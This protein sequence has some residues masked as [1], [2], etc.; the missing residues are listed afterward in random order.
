MPLRWIAIIIFA[1]ALL[2]WPGG[3]YGQTGKSIP[4]TLP[5]KI[6]EQPVE[7]SPAGYDTETCRS[8][9]GRGKDH[10]AVGLLCDAV[11]A[12]WENR[13]L[14]RD[15]QFNTLTVDF[16][17]VALP[18]E[19]KGSVPARALARLLSAPNLVPRY[20]HGGLVLRNLKLDG[21]LTLDHATVD[22]P[23]TFINATFVGVKI[24]RD[25][26]GLPETKYAISLSAARFN[27]RVLI[28]HS[29]I[30][31]PVKIKDSHF[32]RG[33]YFVDVNVFGIES[34]L[35]I[36]DSTIDLALTFYKMRMPATKQSVNIFRST[37]AS[38]VVFNSEL[39]VD[40]QGNA[41]QNVTLIK[42]SFKYIVF[43]RNQ[44]EGQFI[45]N[46]KLEKPLQKQDGSSTPPVV[47]ANRIGGGFTFIAPEIHPRVKRLDLSFNRAEGYSTVYVSQIWNGQVDLTN[48]VFSS[49]LRLAR[50]DP[51]SKSKFTYKT[52]S[53]M[54]LEKLQA[55]KDV[56]IPI[57]DKKSNRRLVVNLTAAEIDT[58]AWNFSLS[59]SN[60]WEGAGLKYK[61]WGD[62]DLKAW[63]QTPKEGE[64]LSDI[65]K[66]EEDFL[67]R[68]LLWR[69][70]MAKPDVDAL[71]YMADY[72]ESR[73]RRIESRD[74]REEAKERNYS[75]PKDPGFVGC[76]F[77]WEC[78]KSQVVLW[79][80]SPGGYG[81]KPERALGLLFI[82]WFVFAIFYKLYSKWDELK[83]GW[84]GVKSELDEVKS[85]WD[86]V[87]IVL[88]KVKSKLFAWKRK[89][90]SW[91]KRKESTPATDVGEPPP[92]FLQ[93][94]QTVPLGPRQ[95]SVWRYSLDA[96]LP[97]INLHAYD[98]Y[99]LRNPKL[100]WIPAFQHV[101][102][103][104][105]ITVFLASVSI[106]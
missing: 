31:G 67:E 32:A 99:F 88:Y 1:Q 4:E 39:P 78:W 97:V 42:D 40:V 33:L 90:Q 80:L 15:R 30:V 94:D 56:Q 84:K 89:M 101:V 103:W 72:L 43:Q 8:V 74:V 25:E 82:G 36:S 54:P 28:S 79:L 27:N 60:R 19:P 76:L 55:C 3:G 24:A 66:T 102:G 63:D 70:T 17:E 5:V 92:G 9:A 38:F 34:T 86:K 35:T 91:A 77:T 81:A 47:S 45:F 22:M 48:G 83:S 20:V 62:P 11:A 75:Y 29:I 73:G 100:R 69:Y 64:K 68:F 49:L 93:I 18:G 85:V 37:I 105:L 26:I 21:P 104:W 52:P 98:R 61:Y 23:I 2:L 44:I 12:A 53:D 46:S 41:F 65:V 59:C 7:V 51:K 95:F 58:L 16:A 10:P 6:V 87:R 71:T 50:Y 13:Q 96:M 57:P 14:D 106:L